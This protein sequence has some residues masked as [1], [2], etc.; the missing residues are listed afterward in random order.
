MLLHHWQALLTPPPLEGEKLLPPDFLQ[1][2]LNLTPVLEFQSV[3][4]RILD[5]NLQSSL[6]KIYVLSFHPLI[7]KSS[8]I[9]KTQEATETSTLTQNPLQTQLKYT[10]LI[11]PIVHENPS[12]LDYFSGQSLLQSPPTNPQS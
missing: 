12:L 2:D 11:I 6:N 9:L 7:M 4:E 1:E 3:R 10:L 5:F 8:F